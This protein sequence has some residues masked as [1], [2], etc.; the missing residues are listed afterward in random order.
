MAMLLIP[1]LLVIGGL[2]ALVYY[3]EKKHGV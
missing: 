1:A 3:L 2:G